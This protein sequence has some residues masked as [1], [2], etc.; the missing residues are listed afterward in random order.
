MPYYNPVDISK[1]FHFITLVC[2]PKNSMYN[3]FA[4]KFHSTKSF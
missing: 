1:C 3:L 2:G 4:N